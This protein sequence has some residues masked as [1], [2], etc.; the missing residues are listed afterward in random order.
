MNQKTITTK[1]E[2]GKKRQKKKTGYFIKTS[3]SQHRKTLTSTIMSRKSQH[4]EGKVVK[5]TTTK[6]KQTKKTKM[7]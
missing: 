4:G 2:G 7:K 1:T 3:N 5:S 6:Q